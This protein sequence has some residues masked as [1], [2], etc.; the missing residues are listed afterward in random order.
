MPEDSSLYSIL[1]ILS[2]V[3]VVVSNIYTAV[4]S[5]VFLSFVFLKNLPVSKFLANHLFSGH[6]SY[7]LFGNGSHPVG[8]NVGGTDI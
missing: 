5:Q 1:G 8:N 3:G 4:A 2:V 6:G 7:L